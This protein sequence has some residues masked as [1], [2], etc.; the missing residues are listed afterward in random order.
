MAVYQYTFDNSTW[1]E[2][3]NV[4]SLRQVAPGDHSLS[5]RTVWAGQASAAVTYNWTVDYSLDSTLLLSGLSAG[6]HEVFI[7]VADADGTPLSSDE[8][9]D[10]KI[11]RLQ[12]LTFMSV[13]LTGL[14]QWVSV[15]V[16]CVTP[17]DDDSVPTFDMEDDEC[18]FCV[19]MLAPND[20]LDP[21]QDF[22][23]Y[24]R[25]FQFCCPS[26]CVDTVH[27]HVLEL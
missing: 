22:G 15:N 4:L 5:V 11:L 1:V 27:Q 12:P 25:Y 8:H 18:K 23:L 17:V 13:L 3:L 10:Y 7:R 26:G 24:D 14:A 6:S 2:C 19:S 9:F 16:T 20:P 21:G